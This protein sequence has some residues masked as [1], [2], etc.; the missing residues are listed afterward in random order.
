MLLLINDTLQVSEYMPDVFDGI[1][2]S[3]TSSRFMLATNARRT[4]EF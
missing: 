4:S 3:S 1:S 2:R